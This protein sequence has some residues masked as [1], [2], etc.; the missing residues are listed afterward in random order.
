MRSAAYLAPFCQHI[1]PLDREQILFTAVRTKID[2]RNQA[3]A[4]SVSGGS[5]G[6]K[7]A[8]ATSRGKGSASDAKGKP[9]ASNVN[10]PTPIP[11]LNRQPPSQPHIPSRLGGNAAISQCTAGTSYSSASPYYAVN[12]Y[13]VTVNQPHDNTRRL[14]A[15]PPSQSHRDSMALFAGYSQVIH[16]NPMPHIMDEYSIYQTHMLNSHNSYPHIQLQSPQSVRSDPY[17]TQ[18]ATESSASGSSSYYNSPH[19][20]F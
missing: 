1:T 8:A 20:S 3:G 9:K 6:R 7:A 18:H 11:P 16:F 17:Y 2:A 19:T 4:P 15:Y 13:P 14:G 5:K 10:T 12:Q